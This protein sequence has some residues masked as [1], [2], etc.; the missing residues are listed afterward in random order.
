[1]LSPYVIKEINHLFKT[2]IIGVITNQIQFQFYSG[3]FV[4]YNN[5]FIIFFDL[6]IDKKHINHKNITKFISD[7]LDDL[8]I[9]IDSAN[10][11]L[12][13][14]VI[15][16]IPTIDIKRFHWNFIEFANSMVSLTYKDY[17]YCCLLPI[18]WPFL[19]YNLYKARF[20][21]TVKVRIKVYFQLTKSLK[22]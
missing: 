11:L 16:Y 8:D 21:H 13:S 3:H 7:H 14:K 12:A 17:L 9:V 5:I 2:K 19:L 20:V 1:M 22:G 15:H 4:K 10:N 6:Y 18:S